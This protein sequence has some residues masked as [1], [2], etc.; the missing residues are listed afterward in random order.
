MR[1]TIRKTVTGYMRWQP[2]EIEVRIN[3]SFQACY[4]SRSGAG[5]DDYNEMT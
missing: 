1:I 4:A 3:T 5:V 2:R